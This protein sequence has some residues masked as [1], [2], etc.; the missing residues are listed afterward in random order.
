MSIL[1]QWYNTLNR[2]VFCSSCKH[3]IAKVKSCTAFN[4]TAI[5]KCGELCVQ[6]YSPDLLKSTDTIVPIV[7]K[8]NRY[9]C[10]SC[11]KE[12]LHINEDNISNIAFTAQCKCGNICSSQN[13]I[14]SVDRRLKST[15]GKISD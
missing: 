1:K 8:G 2:F 13:I 12:L 7:R 10:G 15:V 9:F 11:E 3:L 4:L 5:C 6:K 14:K